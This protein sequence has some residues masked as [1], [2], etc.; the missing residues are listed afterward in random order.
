MKKKGRQNKREA[1]RKPE[2]CART[3]RELIQERKKVLRISVL[4]P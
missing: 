3:D 1:K 4:V 2:S